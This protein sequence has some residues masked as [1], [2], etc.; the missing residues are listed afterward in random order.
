MTTLVAILLS[1]SS[2]ANSSSTLPSLSDVANYVDDYMKHKTPYS[3]RDNKKYSL[4]KLR[5]DS[6]DCASDVTLSG[7]DFSPL[8]PKYVN[9]FPWIGAY[10]TYVV[11][12]SGSLTRYYLTIAEVV[13]LTK[14]QYG[15]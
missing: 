4:I 1:V 12:K 3:A 2:S 14:N 8:S 11:Q 9:S 15:N 10:Q 5:W 13:N 6:V 7:L